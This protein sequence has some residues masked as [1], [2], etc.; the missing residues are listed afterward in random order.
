MTTTI[1]KGGKKRLLFSLRDAPATSWHNREGRSL[2]GGPFSLGP[3]GV[4]DN[5]TTQN[6]TR[7]KTSISQRRIQIG[8]GPFFFF[9]FFFLV[10]LASL[11]SKLISIH[12]F[13]IR[14]NKEHDKSRPSGTLCCWRVK[15]TQLPLLQ[16]ESNTVRCR[17]DTIFLSNLH[18]KAVSGPCGGLITNVERERRCR[19]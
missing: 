2:R 10:W 5:A 19:A 9:F 8:A 18:Y 4:V 11:L 1:G 6:T 7:Q 14:I 3:M 17:H 16:P 13:T 15:W 12:P